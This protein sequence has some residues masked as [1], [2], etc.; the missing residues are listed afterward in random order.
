MEYESLIRQKFHQFC[1]F[2]VVPES[3]IRFL[4]II[5]NIV[6][7]NFFL[8]CVPYSKGQKID[9]FTLKTVFENCFDIFLIDEQIDPNLCFQNMTVIASNY[10]MF[11]IHY[12][13]ENFVS[14][15]NNQARDTKTIRY[16][17]FK[18]GSLQNPFI[19]KLLR[20]NNI[21]L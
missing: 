6:E 18:Y 7:N 13:I 17:H 5:V 1:P 16:V 4:R 8:K 3:L 14:G 9:L 15:I 10:Y 20:D 12:V 21:I 19:R 2:L 11:F